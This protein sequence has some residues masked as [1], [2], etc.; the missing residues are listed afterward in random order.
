MTVDHANIVQALWDAE[1]AEKTVAGALAFVL[2]V[3]AVLPPGEGAGLLL[4]PSGD[5]VI[6][7]Q[8]QMVSAGRIC[9]PDGQL[10]KVLTDVPTKNGP[11]WQD[12]GTVPS[13]QYLAVNGTPGPTPV[14]VPT[15]CDLTPVLKAISDL[16]AA[17]NARIDSLAA[18]ADTRHAETLTGLDDIKKVVAAIQ[19]KPAPNYTTRIFGSLITLIPG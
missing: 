14:P 10:Y 15:P 9:Y 16:G 12:N 19:V 7:Y 2:R 6:D 1:P 4:K 13:A 11:S 18:S 17:L 3:I 5:N 8:G